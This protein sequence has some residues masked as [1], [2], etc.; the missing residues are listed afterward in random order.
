MDFINNLNQIFSAI[1]GFFGMILSILSFVG[2][3][4]SEFL[5]GFFNSLDFVFN[6][7]TGFCVDMYNLYLHLPSFIHYGLSIVF[8][9]TVTVFIM[10]LIKELVLFG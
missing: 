7:F 5:S 6:F 8:F 4:V 10:K 9:F 2:S 1:A 3:F